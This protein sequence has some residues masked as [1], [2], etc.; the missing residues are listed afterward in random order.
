MEATSE[1]LKLAF[2]WAASCGGCEI[3]L[4]EIGDRI[5]KVVELADLV[6]C[7]CLVDTKYKDIEAMPDGTLDVTFINGAIRSSENEHVAKL[8]RKK[9][10]VLIAYGACA[11]DGGIPSLANLFT[12]QDIKNRAYHETE[13]TDNPQHIEPQ[14]KHTEAGCELTLPELWNTVHKLS[15]VVKVDYL[16]PGCA[17]AAETIWN[18]IEQL[19]TGALPPPGNVIGAGKK[20][21]C[22]ECPYTKRDERITAFYRPHLFKTDSDQ[23][24]LEQGLVCLGAA[25]RSGCG[26]Q[27]LQCGM[28][29]RGCYG[30]LPDVEDMGAKMISAIGS[31]V[32]STDEEEVKAVMDQIED[33]AGTLYRFTLANSLLVRRKT[34]G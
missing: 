19:V 15:D 17:P 16:L 34:D 24:L 10:K 13:S 1:K 22:E 11:C 6:F 30:A 14:L 29:C 2:Y 26:A 9:S 20:A 27:C 8:L 5:L 4:L 12:V 31:L 28:P 7:P 23:C 25:T 21:V 32:A 18:A 33:P 3:S